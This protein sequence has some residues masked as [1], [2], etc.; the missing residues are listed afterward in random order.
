[1]VEIYPLLKNRLPVNKIVITDKIR[2]TKIFKMLNFS[3]RAI[4]TR[5]KSVVNFNIP[6][7]RLIKFPPD[8]LTY[9]IILTK[10]VYFMQL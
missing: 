4:Q 7:M 10:A 1:Y 6:Y 8:I 3:F 2:P 9:V 5:V